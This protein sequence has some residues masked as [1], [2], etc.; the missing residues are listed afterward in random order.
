MTLYSLAI[1]IF[2][3]YSTKEAAHKLG[4]SQVHMKLLARKGFIN[5]RK[6][7]RDWVILDLNYARKRTPKGERK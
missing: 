7:G 2:K 5:A 6:I 3:M 1:I 4:L